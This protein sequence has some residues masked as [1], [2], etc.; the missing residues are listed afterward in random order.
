LRVHQGVHR[1]V[2]DSGWWLSSGLV[3]IPSPLVRL[4]DRELKVLSLVADGLSN[5]AIA[6]L[7]NV[8]I[9]TLEAICTSMFRKLDLDHSGD[10]NRR[11]LAAVLY[12]KHTAELRD[13]GAVPGRLNSFVGRRQELDDV[14]A[15]LRN[16][17]LVTI[18]GPGGSGKTSLAIAL[19]AA[20][21]EAGGR[22]RVVELAARRGRTHVADALFEAFGVETA[23]ERVGIRRIRALVGSE[24]MLIVVDNAEHVVGPV[25]WLIG[26]LESV[27]GLRMVVTSRSPLHTTREH[28]WVIPPLRPSDAAELLRA[29]V[30]AELSDDEVTGVCAAADGLPLAIELIAAQFSSTRVDRV[31]EHL[32]R[33]HALS[34][35]GGL[36]RHRS[37]AAALDASY[38][39]LGDRARGVFRALSVPVDGCAF[40]VA[41]ACAGVDDGFDD[42]LDELVVSSLIDYTRGRY[43][44]V[45]PVRQ[46]AEELLDQH[47]ERDGVE[48]RFVESIAELG[49]QAAS[50]RA[51][52][53]AQWDTTIKR[54][55]S[56]IDHAVDLA[57]RHGPLDNGLRIVARLGQHWTTVNTAVGYRLS[58]LVL[59]ACQGNE[60]SRLVGRAMASTANLGSLLE[61]DGEWT[62]MFERAIELLDAAG[63][64]SGLTNAL[65]WFGRYNGDVATVERTIEIAEETGNEL[66]LAW[67]LINK[68]TLLAEHGATFTACLPL[69]ERAGAI[70][71][72]NSLPLLRAAALMRT[73]SC[74]ELGYAPDAER[75]LDQDIASL[76]AE[77]ETIV[78]AFGDDWQKYE[79]VMLQARLRLA[80]FELDE[81]LPYV[82]EAM[83]LAADANAGPLLAEAI[84]LAA[85]LA[86]LAVRP[87]DSA[88]LIELATTVA[89]RR[90]EGERASL[91]T[92]WNTRWHPF[93]RVRVHDPADGSLSELDSLSRLQS[94]QAEARKLL[95]ATRP[96]EN[97]LKL[98]TEKA[99]GPASP[100][101]GRGN[102]W[103]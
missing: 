34:A 54:E 52:N 45:E 75:V 22:V 47:G 99:R 82:R 69:F 64:R 27:A 33:V 41:R 4:T 76:A 66:T 57:I 93:F 95:D 42:S 29:R 8:S 68:A 18:V 38:E 30:S 6:R 87:D 58:R 94:T 62:S 32:D 15:L 59:D 81:A 97:H 98:E 72:N 23:D 60:P 3:R 28:V 39:L 16:D 53:A 12:V 13:V 50:G 88:S 101:S 11:V 100:T 70:G 71:Q 84:A 77:A 67:S 90:I 25:V 91:T 80:V 96:R 79:M 20:E 40:D 48:A 17:R 63:D 36:E 46:Y 9:K 92:A 61:H 19:A 74:H 86:H 26:Q 83:Q 7:L 24:P 1:A 85:T 103:I 73:V 37:V 102:P 44:M 14:V 43:R 2:G 31:M 51:Q 5:D 89:G 35:P 10:A 56:N 21:V 49:R 55:R 78:R 65:Y